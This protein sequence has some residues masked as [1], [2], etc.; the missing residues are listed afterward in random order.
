[1]VYALAYG[2][3]FMRVWC[4]FSKGRIMIQC[5]GAG[6]LAM[7]QLRLMLKL[8]G[9]I[10]MKTNMKTSRWLSIAVLGLASSVA[11]A[12]T[13]FA[14]TDGD[15]NFLYEADALSGYTLA[16]FDDVAD[17][18]T[19][20]FLEVTAPEL[21]FWDGIDRLS[22]GRST[23]ANSLTIDGDFVL[24]ISGDGGNSWTGG[25]AD[26]DSR[27][28]VPEVNTYVVRFDGIGGIELVSDLAPVPVPAAVWLFGTGLIG[29]IA[30]ARRKA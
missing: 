10:N 7:E 2:D 3:M 5:S 27:F 29:M 1:M 24:A 21:I 6:L 30:V 9:K 8:T 26:F 28:T 19:D 13:I 11:N 25:E 14:P 23:A 12:A 22:D 20:A 16:I 18:G 15:I 4:W 17:F